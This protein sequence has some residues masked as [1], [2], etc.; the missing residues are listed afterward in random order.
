MTESRSISVVESDM[1]Y[2]RTSELSVVEDVYVRVIRCLKA[3]VGE[4]GE[5]KD[6]ER[7]LETRSTK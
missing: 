5:K 3:V 7:E 6:G 4:K 2:P 1:M